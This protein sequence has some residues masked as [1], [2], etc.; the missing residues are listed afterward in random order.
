VYLIEF[1]LPTFD[2]HGQ[3]FP[4]SEFDRVRRELTERFGG[5][6]AY[7]RSPAVG[8]WTDEAGQVRQ[9]ELATFE[10]MADTLAREWWR[11]YRGL[12]QQRFRQD[13]I[14][15]RATTFERL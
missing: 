11:E 14:V 1:L 12:L 6:T 15:I 9:D 5:V 2:N 13:E 8:L 10:V 3:H 7:V 4:K